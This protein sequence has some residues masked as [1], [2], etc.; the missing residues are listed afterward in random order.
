[1]KPIN[2]PTLLAIRD[3]MPAYGGLLALSSVLPILFLA[4][5]FY[6]WQIM[7]RVLHSHN[8][9]TMIVLALICTFL[10]LIAVLIDYVR[11][12]S[13]QRLGIQIDIRLSQKFFDSLYRE[14]A[15]TRLSPNNI[16]DLNFV[17]EFLSGPV[18]MT[19]MD[20]IWSPLL[21][22]VLFMMHWVFGVVA[23][24]VL[25]T[26]GALVLLEQSVVGKDSARFREVSSAEAAYGAS[27]SRILEP[28]RAMG[29]LP[30]I[31]SKWSRLHAA[32]LGWRY[33]AHRRADVIVAISRFVNLMIYIVLVT[34]AVFLYLAGEVGGSGMII[35]VMLMLRATGPI[36]G[37][38]RN[39]ERIAAFGASR[40]RLDAV[41]AGRDDVE[42]M[43]LPAPTGPLIVSR[44]WGGAPNSDKII[45]NDVSFTVAPGRV[46]AVV[47]PS[48]AGKSCLARL[49]VNVW[50]PRRGAVTLGDNDF[51]HWNA[52]ELGRFVGYVPQDIEFMPGT[53]AENIARLDP[54][55]AKRSDL[56]VAAVELAGIQDVVR[57]LPDGYNTRIG[58]GGYV[59]SGGQRQRLAL[60]RAV[61]ND[62]HLIVMDE[63]NAHLDAGG[64]KALGDAILRLRSQ[65]K[66]VV[67]ITHRMSL[68]AF[69]DDLLVL[70]G[71]AV[72]AFG[73]RDQI[74][75]RLPRL[76][77]QP[78]LTVIGG[79]AEGRE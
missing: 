7:R 39:W 9:N 1:M 73:E 3:L 46:L 49:L 66:V 60:A 50:T 10:L 74:V 47:G 31:R 71:G 18:I 29:M 19:I 65:G 79:N 51:T 8:V 13:L 54:E 75:N 14:D 6:G 37:L 32:M 63:P 61:F 43:S 41:I 45:I 30:S 57:A 28:A 35:T 33:E 68:L 23:F 44:V 12:K 16:A 69:C 52:D 34:T 62:P 20:A 59:L 55:M 24:A 67:I 2:S 27:A 64:E 15:S 36:E 11:T 17:R 5:P 48:G 40:E 4:G 77:A 70:N 56:I 38:I 76:K 26:I 21:I 25:A 72:Q 78:N 53:V 58:V 22:L 42:R